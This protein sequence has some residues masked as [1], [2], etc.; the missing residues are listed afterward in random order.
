MTLVPTTGNLIHVIDSTRY[1]DFTRVSS[2]FT[3]MSTQ[4]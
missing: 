2:F 4:G 3:Y 1:T